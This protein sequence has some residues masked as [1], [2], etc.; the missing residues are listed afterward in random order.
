MDMYPE[1][2]VVVFDDNSPDP[3]VAEVIRKFDCPVRLGEGGKGRHGGLYANMQMA[4]EAALAEGYD[5]LLTLQDDLQLL[6]PV[7]QRVLG[8]FDAE[9]ERYP[10]VASLELRFSRTLRESGIVAPG[11][12]AVDAEPNPFRDYQDVSL[13]H[14][15]RLEQP[16]LS[17]P[18]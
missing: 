14:L 2:H 17:G 6:R 8:E 10:N 15:G 4:Y 7:D 16:H 5:Y 18:I 3:E 13:F 9:F 11:P 1:A 12:A